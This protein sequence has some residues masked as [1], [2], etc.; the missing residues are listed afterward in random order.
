VST[1]DPLRIP[2]ALLRFTRASQSFI[3]EDG[4]DGVHNDPPEERL[5]RKA[6]EIFSNEFVAQEAS[7]FA[8]VATSQMNSVF[9][10]LLRDALGAFE[11]FLPEG[12]LNDI[13]R[14]FRM[15]ARIFIITL[16]AS[17]I[18][19]IYGFYSIKLQRLVELLGLVSESLARVSDRVSEIQVEVLSLNQ[20]LTIARNAAVIAAA[21]PLAEE[22]LKQVDAL[23]EKVREFEDRDFTF[24]LPGIT[25]VGVCATL[26]SLAD[27]LT[28]EDIPTISIFGKLSEIEAELGRLLGLIQAV[29]DEVL[30][31]LDFEA[32]I[33][34]SRSNLASLQAAQLERLRRILRFFI[35]A[36]D[37]FNDLSPT[38][39]AQQASSFGLQFK[40]VAS[41]LCRD[42][43]SLTD[44][45]KDTIEANTL[46][47]INLALAQ[48]DLTPLRELGRKVASFTAI[49]RAH[50]TQDLGSRFETEILAVVAAINA[51]SLVVDLIRAAAAPWTIVNSAVVDL[52]E[53][54]YE[55]GGFAEG[56]AALVG[57]G[58]FD[59]VS[60]A[61][62]HTQSSSGILLTFIND[63]IAATTNDAERNRLFRARDILVGFERS[64]AAAKRIDNTRRDLT[65]NESAGL[66]RKVK[67]AETEI[68]KQLAK[69]EISVGL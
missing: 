40:S 57:D 9:T 52:I 26:R 16:L 1:T 2:A 7:E 55:A 17:P 6:A 39:L 48:I 18:E 47:A 22:L 36:S 64:A 10:T 68:L 61:A 50:I 42:V 13:E 15:D 25:L 21:G 29:I 32:N 31:S 3:S 19:A 43:G 67:Q 49:T 24:N 54:A 28:G 11:G 44:V 37:Q 58:D 20:A 38:V 12:P 33:I 63:R 34:N 14:I 30:G 8:A 4:I 53:E 27:L 46:N 35:D 41:I 56:L 69:L 45:V 60:V 51:A 23:Y 59:S 65:I 5:A 62:S 66:F